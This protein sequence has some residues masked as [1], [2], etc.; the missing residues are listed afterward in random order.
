M[1]TYNCAYCAKEFE[2]NRNDAK[3]CSS[4]CRKALSRKS[5]TET[6][7]CEFCARSFSG[8]GK[9]C[10]KSCC[11]K[12]FRVSNAEAISADFDE[13]AALMQ[14]LSL[15]YKKSSLDQ[16][17][18]MIVNALE[19]AL[20]EKKSLIDSKRKYRKHLRRM[21]QN[22]NWVNGRTKDFKLKGMKTFPQVVN[23]YCISLTGENIRD[24]MKKPELYF[25][26]EKE[27]FV[28][29]DDLGEVQEQLPKS[30]DFQEW[31]S[32]N[33]SEEP[34]EPKKKTSNIIQFTLTEKE[35]LH[36]TR[37]ERFEQAKKNF[38]HLSDEKINRQLDQQDLDAKRREERKR[39]A[40]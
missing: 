16:Q 5:K 15:H 3:T 19:I 28:F 7:S 1:K 32:S 8:K 21:F 31:I 25:K 36:M 38:P 6:K 40:L 33:K 10:S 23:Q 2:S 12:S 27:A 29:A 39:L 26:S 4:N 35:D 13:C 24:L 34:E 11:D 30:A 18:A 9:F 14:K 17:K 20:V 37:E 22:N